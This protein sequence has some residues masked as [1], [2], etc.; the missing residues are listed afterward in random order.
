MTRVNDLE[1]A[2]L[3]TLDILERLAGTG[4][5]KE[6]DEV[7]GVPLLDG[8]PHL[9]VFLEAA[10]ARAVPGSGI[11]DHDRRLARQRL[12][13]IGR[14]DPQER[15][16]DGPLLCPPVD[17]HFVGEGKQRRHSL[18]S[19]V[20]HCVRA[21]SQ[22]LGGHHRPLPRVDPVLGHLLPELHSVIG[23]HLHCSSRGD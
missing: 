3:E 21:A 18:G 6:G 7:G 17:N 1:E 8:D 23:P 15:V 19:M 5:G 20:E 10:D 16:V 12:P 2:R 22:R 9:G 11:D 4:M 14:H 13:A